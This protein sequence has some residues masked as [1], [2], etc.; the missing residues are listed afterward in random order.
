MATPPSTGSNV[1]Q[2]AAPAQTPAP[3]TPVPLDEEAKKLKLEQTK[4]EARKAIAEANKATLTAQLPTSDMKPLEGKTE[5]GDKAGLVADLLAHSLLSPASKAIAYGVAAA[6]VPKEATVLVVDDRA[7]TAIDWSYIAVSK[8]VEHQKT[9]LDGALEL[10]KGEVPKDQQRGAETFGPLMLPGAGALLQA[11][12]A[13]IGAAATVVGMFQSDYA[14]KARDVSIGTTPLIAAV[15]REL[16]GKVKTAVSGFD[17]VRDST[18]GTSFWDAWDKRG[19]L[20]RLRFLLNGEVSP[21][22]QQI[23]DLRGQLKQ[24]GADY[25]KAVADGKDAQA[26]ATLSKRVDDL[27]SGL[28][29]AEIDV[30]PKRAL[31]ALADAVIA[32]FDAFTNAVTTAK[33]GAAYPPLVA[34]GIHERLHDDATNP[35][36]YVLYVG[37]EAASGETITRRSLFKPSGAVGFLGGANVSYLL[38]KTDDGTTIAAGSEPLL[39][40][41]KYD[42][43]NGEVKSVSQV[44]VAVGIGNPQFEQDQ[45]LQGG[46]VAA[47]APQAAQLPP[48]APGDPDA[49]E[50][51]PRPTDD[52]R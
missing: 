24:A 11:A 45:R 49:P 51:A 41:L 20:E 9:A 42:L 36:A 23:E 3:A 38:L 29:Q 22:D 52:Q 7:L 37:V 25:D 43:W 10:V 8:Q 44:D 30:A 34:A 46:P 2:P 14:I 16:Q 19:E 17:V 12:P 6:G 50:E 5:V 18:V 40:H 1:E 33:E 48:P 35:I 31:V 27:Y 21:V 39:A 15:V 26:I 13:L 4:A 32:R 28:T 47:P